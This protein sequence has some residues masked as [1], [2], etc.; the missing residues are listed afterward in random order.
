MFSWDDSGLS[1]L[2]FGGYMSRLSHHKKKR[3]KFLSHSQQTLKHT[4]QS[5]LTKTCDSESTREVILSSL[6][7]PS[8]SMRTLSGMSKDTFLTPRVIAVAIQNDP[9][10]R[11]EVKVLSRKS[12][13]GRRLFMS[14]Q[15]Y[16]KESSWL[17]RFV[18]VFSSDRGLDISLDVG[19]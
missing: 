19:V 17:D 1:T 6:Q 11:S 7:D 3:S 10:L 13:D 5:K 14:R 15:R 16:L 12:K 2:R 8:Y 9:V 4:S 18:D